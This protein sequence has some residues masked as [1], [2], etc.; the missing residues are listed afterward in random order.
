M[1]TEC[2]SVLAK[3]IGPIAAQEIDRLIAEA[4]GGDPHPPVKKRY[5]IPL[6]GVGQY[7]IPAETAPDGYHFENHYCEFISATE[8]ITPPTEWIWYTIA[9]NTYHINVQSDKRGYVCRLTE[10]YEYGPD[11][12]SG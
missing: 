11:P 2:S 4:V 12:W 9:D 7:D 8:A 10:V 6:G 3:S 5:T 1:A